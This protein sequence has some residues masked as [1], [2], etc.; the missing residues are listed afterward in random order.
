MKILNLWL[1]R[2]SIPFMLDHL[3]N[4]MWANVKSFNMQDSIIL[5]LISGSKCWRYIIDHLISTFRYVFQDFKVAQLLQNWRQRYLSNPRS[6][7]DERSERHLFPFW[8]VLWQVLDQTKFILDQPQSHFLSGPTSIS[9]QTV[10]Y[11]DR[12]SAKIKF[13]RDLAKHKQ[14][15][16]WRKEMCTTIQTPSGFW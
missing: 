14:H 11:S 1:I 5:N 15:H 4:I 8:L 2:T 7:N 16:H 9:I 10:L 6:I 13:S 3:M 12:P